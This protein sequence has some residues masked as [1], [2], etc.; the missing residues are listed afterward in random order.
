MTTTALMSNV[1]TSARIQ[2]ICKIA[3]LCHK[4]M[5]LSSSTGIHDLPTEVVA[6]VMA[7]L[8]L[9]KRFKFRTI[10]RNFMDSFSYGAAW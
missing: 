5:V 2:Y 9:E 8:H 1:C 4:L 10:S 6:R 7:C 3:L